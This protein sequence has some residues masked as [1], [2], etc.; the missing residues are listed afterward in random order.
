MEDA[1]HYSIRQD[2]G[3]DRQNIFYVNTTYKDPTFKHILLPVWISAYKFKDKVYQFMINARTGEVQG[4]RPYSP[5]KIG[6]TIFVVLLI[7]LMIY[8]F[9]K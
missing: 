1:I 2:I 4:D 3:G 6:L 5:V 7:V 8:L 9:S